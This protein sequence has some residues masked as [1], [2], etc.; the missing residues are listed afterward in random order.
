VRLDHNKVHAFASPALAAEIGPKPDIA[1]L[2]KQTFV[3]STALPESFD[4]W[5]AALGLKKLEPA[6]I[7]HYDSGNCWFR[8]PRRALASPSCTTT[9]S[10]ARRREAGAPVR[11]RGGQPLQLLVRVPPPRAGNAACADFSRLAGEGGV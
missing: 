2:A 11:C 7:D 9:T 1:R 5:K 3:V 6:A 8:P 10:C 4:V